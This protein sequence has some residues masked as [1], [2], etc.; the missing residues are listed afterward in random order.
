LVAT[1]LCRDEPLALILQ[2]LED[3]EAAKRSVAAVYGEVGI[4]K[5]RLVGVCKSMAGAPSLAT[6]E[7]AGLGGN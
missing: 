1:N 3:A 7:L 2:L 5:T 6:P 4:G